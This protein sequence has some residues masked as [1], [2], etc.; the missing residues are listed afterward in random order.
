MVHFHACLLFF[1]SCCICVC[2]EYHVTMWSLTPRR[3]ARRNVS[4][5]RPIAREDHGVEQEVE[6]CIRLKLRVRKH[7]LRKPNRNYER[8]R[9][10]GHTGSSKQIAWPMCLSYVPIFSLCSLFIFGLCNV[11][12]VCLWYVRFLVCSVKFSVLDLARL[13]LAN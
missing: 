2:D 10:R 7:M 5:T 8:D 3:V 11:F 12:I 13:W 1:F 6:R 9:L 4:N